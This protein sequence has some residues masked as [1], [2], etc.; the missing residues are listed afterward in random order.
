M[1]G[2]RQLALSSVDQRPAPP[3]PPLPP[4]LLLLLLLLFLLFLLLILLPVLVLLIF[5]LV[6]L[7]SLFDIHADMMQSGLIYTNLYM[8]AL[9]F[10]ALHGI[11]TAG[12]RPS[13]HYTPSV[14]FRLQNRWSM[15]LSSQPLDFPSPPPSASLINWLI[16]DGARRI[17]HACI[18]VCI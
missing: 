11:D 9:C 14:N 15:P 1:H 8:H 18:L 13:M 2:S 6:L 17:L 7:L 12:S 4:P 3:V 10:G 5:L 16:A